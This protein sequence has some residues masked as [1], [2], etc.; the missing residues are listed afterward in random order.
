MAD[1]Y[2]MPVLCE[3]VRTLL[4]PRPGGRYLDMTVGGG[5]HAHMVLSATGPDG[6]LLGLDRDPDALVASAARLAPFAG[7]FT[8]AHTPFDHAADAAADAGF[9]AF[10]GILMDLGVSSWQINTP[11]RGFS[12][13]ADGPLDM[14]MDPT[15][16]IPT[17]ADLVATLDQTALAD[18][19]YQYG[20][21]RLSRRIARAIIGAREERPITTTAHLARVVSAAVPK[22]AQQRIHPA[23][24][25]F[26]AL[27]IAVNDELGKL[28]S[29]L[30]TAFDLLAPQGRLA[31]ISFHSLEDR[32]VKAR[33]KALATGC[34][35]PPSFPIC[36]CHRTPRADL[37]IRGA[38]KGTDAEINDNPRAR[39]A[40]LR[41]LI[42]RTPDTDVEAAS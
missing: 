34:I 25:T 7:R 31:V 22:K 10:D 12:F 3:Q 35:C 5:G 37:V 32:M 11:A 13:M 24:R 23:T 42:K 28:D 4:A 30:D 14:R 40:R 39:S 33:F 20:E 26:Q 2:H 16:D 19:I 9:D 38:K 18:L 27:R 6:R 29:A 8:L 1:G 17:A 41:A 21:E 15:A 36:N